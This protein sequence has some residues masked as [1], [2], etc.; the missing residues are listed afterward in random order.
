V[1]VE[2]MKQCVPGE[3]RCAAFIGARSRINYLE[4]IRWCC[5]LLVGEGCVYV[6]P[7]HVSSP[8]SLWA[9][10]SAPVATEGFC[11]TGGRSAA[12]DAKHGCATG[13]LRLTRV[14][15]ILD[16]RPPIFSKSSSGALLLESICS[17]WVCPHKSV[18][19]WPDSPHYG[20]PIT[21]KGRP[22]MLF[23]RAPHPSPPTSRTAQR[24]QLARGFGRLRSLP[25]LPGPMD[26]PLKPAPCRHDPPKTAL[27]RVCPI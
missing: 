12:R 17:W 25:S 3:T 19:C 26:P 21:H 18:D 7:I 5:S 13:R 14:H 8:P 16:I 15:S 20:L 4:I 2:R 6:F 27:L 22:V 9:D 11:P 10:E 24:V 1:E 23:G